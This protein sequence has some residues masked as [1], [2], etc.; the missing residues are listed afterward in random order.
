MVIRDRDTTLDRTAGS[1]L[2]CT[3]ARPV[4]SPPGTQGPRR[5]EVS[6]LEANM[7]LAEMHMHFFERDGIPMR[8]CGLNRFSPNSPVGV[9]PCGEGWVGI[10]ITTPDQWRALCQA[11]PLPEQAADEGLV[12]RELRFARQDEVEAALVRVLATRSASAW[13][14]IG[15]AHRV[16]NV[17]VPAAAGTTHTPGFP[18]PA[19]PARPPP[20]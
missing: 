5:L 9:Y 14:A 2:D 1:T 7:V 17:A 16:P 4:E 19:P 13:A 8:R 15:V 18:Q 20:R 10:T 3:S 11:L 12:T 6:I